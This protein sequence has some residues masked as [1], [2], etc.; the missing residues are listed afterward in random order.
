MNEETEL[1][2]VHYALFGET[3]LCLLV[4]KLSYSDPSYAIKWRLIILA[5]Q[6]VKVWLTKLVISEEENTEVFS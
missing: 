6:L 5:M 4:F 1:A 3:F 2:I